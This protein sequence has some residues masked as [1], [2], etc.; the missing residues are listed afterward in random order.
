MLQ[1]QKFRLLEASLVFAAAA[2]AGCAAKYGTQAPAM[3][4]S[5]QQAQAQ[6]QIKQAGVNVSRQF[7][8]RWE[9]AKST[10]K[11]SLEQC[12]LSAGSGY[13]SQ[14]ACWAQLNNQASSYAAE[15]AGMSVSGLT[16]AQLQSFS[17]A[18]Q[19]AV[20]FFH[21][22]SQYATDCSVSTESCLR[23]QDLRMQMNSERKAVDDYLMHASIASNGLAYE[24]G[25]VNNNLESLQT[26]VSVPPTAQQPR[27][28]SAQ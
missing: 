17:L 6:A 15:F 22:S 2:L 28:Q 9:A 16:A 11:N 3:P 12:S 13:G 4:V 20:N 1:I 14:R 27:I 21:L 18:K 5:L 7:I 19:A 24:N 26:P 23:N 10:M 8:G 25:A